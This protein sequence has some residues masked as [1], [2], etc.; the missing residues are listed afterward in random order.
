MRHVVVVGTESDNPFAIDV[1]RFCGQVEDISDLISLKSFANG[2]FCPRFITAN[3]HEPGMSLEGQ[4][5]A[6]VSTGSAHLTRGALA[7]RTLLVARA[8]RD[9]GAGAVVLVEPDLFFS[10]QDRGPRLDHGDTDFVRDESDLK[11]FDGQPFSARLYAQTLGLAGVDSVLTVHNHSTSVGRELEREL[12]G[13]YRNLSPAGIFAQ[14]VRSSDVLDCGEDG[15]RLAVCAPDAG[16]AHFAGDVREALGLPGVKVMQLEKQRDG[17]R[18]V[19]ST[20]SGQSEIGIDEL[21]GKDVLIVDDMV[22]TGRTILEC[23]TKLRQGRPRRIV[24]AVTHFYSSAENRE[25]LS[26]PEL[27]EIITTNTIPAILNRDTQG[28]LRKKLVVLKLERWLARSVLELLGV[29]VSHLD[30]RPF[31]VDMSSKNP[32]W[33]PEIR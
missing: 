13:V 33:T 28:R 5:V 14:Y 26:R 15:S 16:A 20:V 24:F 6:I 2:E 7:M 18:S 1:G 32:R 31:A 4:S 21:D 30:D 27:D 8:A 23:S 11:K 10:A 9:N 22:R 19:T 12:D 29:D 25:L 3:D 17:E